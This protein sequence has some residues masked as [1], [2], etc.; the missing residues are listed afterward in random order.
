[1]NKLRFLLDEHISRDVA[2]GLRKAGVGVIVDSIVDWKD[3]ILLGSDD[4]LL[5]S[6]AF[7][8][9]RT[10]VTYDQSTIVPLLKEW[11]EQGI[12]H[13]GVVFIDDRTIPSNDFGR[14]IRALLQLWREQKESDWRNRVVY[15]V[16]PKRR[17][18]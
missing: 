16:K 8:D 18:P 13:G 3:G 9:K 15:L 6:T 17:H 11:G 10:L 7:S 4:A 2:I 14:L 12:D 5:V 1:V